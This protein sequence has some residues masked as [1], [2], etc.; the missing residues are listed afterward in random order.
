MLPIKLELAT[1]GNA[2]DKRVGEALHVVAVEIGGRLVQG[3]DAAVK[4]E[5]LRK[6]QTDDERG[7][8]L[9]SSAASPAHVELSVT[10]QHHNLV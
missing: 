1:K 2:L 3:E 6:R 9:L 4:A 8:Y 5:R 10:F 7:E